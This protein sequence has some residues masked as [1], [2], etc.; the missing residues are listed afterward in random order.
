[1]T[2]PEIFTFISV[3]IF[4][5]ILLIAYISTSKKGALEWE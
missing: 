1:M 5:G 4:V 3:T 2:L